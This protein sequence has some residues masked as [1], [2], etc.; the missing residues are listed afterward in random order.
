MNE[1]TGWIDG[2]H[3]L[4]FLMTLVLVVVFCT[5]CDEV[6]PRQA[7]AAPPPPP[8]KVAKPLVKRVTEW[9]TFTGR[10]EAVERVDIRARVSGYL[11]GVHFTD[12]K[13]VTKGDLLFTIDPRPFEAAV[14]HARAEVQR[15][16]AQVDRDSRNY[17][18]AQN[19]LRSNAV[20][21]EQ[22]DNRRA[23]KLGSEAEL[24]AAEAQLRTAELDLEF[25][26]IT[27]PVAGRISDRKVD[28]GN[29]ITG[30]SADAAPLAT[31]VSLDP[32]YFV[33]DASEA[34]YLKYNRLARSGDRPS[35]RE[36]ANPVYVQL[37]DETGWTRQGKMNFVDNV[38]S[39]GSGTIRGRAIFDNPD[40][41]LAPGLF[42]RLRL[43]GS[44]AY[45]A[46]LL[47]DD[48]II[49]DQSN[50]IAFVVRA[51]DTAEVRR[52]TLGPIIDGLRVIRS[53][54]AADDRVVV[55]GIQ[56]VRNGSK[57]TP[58]TT[59]VAANGAAAP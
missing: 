21:A 1:K 33:F 19:L 54:I 20:S 40:F 42:G 4:P 25:T 59:T 48:A 27:A 28:V 13:M 29:L 56:R 47:P 11:A 3:I 14:A 17:V 32:I 36:T 10:F 8:V 50:K 35:S 37:I 16:E 5:G 30:G 15:L 18:R 41:L 51:D 23:D 26:R 55:S 57:V 31:I 24:A 52:V 53:G 43:I 44:G 22:V 45:E 58:E 2:R 34:D 6:K 49:A 38:F 7:A 39:P 12:G 9:D 46:I